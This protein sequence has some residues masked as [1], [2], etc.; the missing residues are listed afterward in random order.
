MSGDLSRGHEAAILVLEQV[1]GVERC[2]CTKLRPG[3]LE[4]FANVEVSG[5]RRKEW[6]IAFVSFS[7]C[8][9]VLSCVTDNYATEFGPDD[10][11]F[12]KSESICGPQGP[13]VR[14]NCR[15][16]HSPVQSRRCSFV[17]AIEDDSDL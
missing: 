13:E 11:S 17:E 1:S 9:I 14:S 10:T 16:Q 7:A 5:A 12:E 8:L 3:Q 6:N 15:E 2:H 4:Q